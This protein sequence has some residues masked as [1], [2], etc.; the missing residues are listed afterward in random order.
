MSEKV[1]LINDTEDVYHWGCYGTSHAIKQQLIEKGL[2]LTATVPVYDVHKLSY[3]ALNTNEYGT[4]ETFCERLPEIAAKMEACDLIIVNGEGTIHDFSG[5]ARALL[6]LIYAGKTFFG[7]KVNLINHSCF[8]NSDDPEVINFYKN[9]YEKCDFITA[10]EKRSVENI[11]H[12]LGVKCSLA[13]D[14]LPLTAKRVERNLSRMIPEPY[15]CV[16]GAVNYKHHRSEAIAKRLMKEYPGHRFIYLAG[17]KEE[18]IHFEEP[19]VYDSLKQFIPHI[20]MYGATSFEEWLSIIKHASLLISGRY[21]YTIGGMC[22]GTPMVYFPSNT[23]KI[24]VIAE[25]YGLPKPTFSEND[26]KFKIKLYLALKKA[27]MRKWKNLT[28]TLCQ[29]SIK[30]YKW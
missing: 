11:T 24:D 4:K 28:D 5:Y 17:S 22:T 9:A 13:F 19:I 21:H 8:P 10:R 6:F 7:K 3:Y 26:F 1:L 25:E 20:E 2:Q 29:S 18:G 30:N 15:V 12:Q 23:P 14:S 16:S 27:K